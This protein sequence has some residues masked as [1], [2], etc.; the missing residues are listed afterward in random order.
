MASSSSTLST[1]SASRPHTPFRHTHNH[2]HSHIHTS[3]NSSTTSSDD[4][5]TVAKMRIFVSRARDLVSRD[6]NGYSDPYVKLTI[7]GHKFTTNVVRKSLNPVW[8]AAFDFELD[9]QS[10]PDQITLMFWDKDRWGRDDYLGTVYIPLQPSSLWA[11]SVPKHFDDPDNQASLS[12]FL[13]HT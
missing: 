5:H 12:I 2:H 7:G 11:D 1:P 4:D 3:T 6:R 9:A 8:D 13:I 10:M